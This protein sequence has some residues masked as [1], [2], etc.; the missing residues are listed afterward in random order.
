[1]DNNEV[2]IGLGNVATDTYSYINNLI[3]NP[4][5][6]VIIVIVLIIYV[7]LF[8][9]LG[10][11]GSEN[12]ELYSNSSSSFWVIVA[13]I[14]LLLLV[15]GNGLLQYIFSVDIFASIKNL[16]QPNTQLDIVVDQRNISSVPEIKLYP[17]VFNIPE[18]A[19][20]YEDAKALC[21]AYNARLATYQELEDT[22][23]RGG[24]WCN[25]GWSEGQM[26]LFPTQQ[27]TWDKLQTI[28]GHEN[29]CGRPG[30]NGGYIDNP[31]IKFGVNCYGNKPK[32]TEE[33][34]VLM[35]TQPI[36]PKTMKD[37]LMEK[38]VTYWK[39]RLPEINVSPFN[40]Y[41]WSKI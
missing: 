10:S 29:D 40:H 24:E 20:G 14:L 26:A 32:M 37:I 1:M 12:T 11:E 38:R 18:N 21:K 3:S 31:H 7:M 8:A 15:I 33:E 28:K 2:T 13:V 23:N 41:Q 35:A 9:T 19:Y 27:K 5:V 6:I 36:Y 4:V 22:Y 30:V 34:E 25:Y 16:F 17:Q 39:E